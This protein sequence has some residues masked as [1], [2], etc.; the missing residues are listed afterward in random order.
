M[1]H[2]ILV[3]WVVDLEPIDEC[4][5]Y[6]LIEVVYFC[7]LVIELVE[8]MLEAPIRLYYNGEEIIAIVVDF[9]M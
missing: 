7:H 6:I 4:G 5:N 1:L 8:I 9:P 2:Q 3:E